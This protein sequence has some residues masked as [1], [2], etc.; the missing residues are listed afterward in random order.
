M[1]MKKI[2][3]VI[4]IC[5][6][7][8]SSC[9]RKLIP[10]IKTEAGKKYD[11]ATFNYVYAEALRQKLMGNN[12]DALKFLE[13]CLKINPN[14]DAV[15]FQMAQIVLGNGDINNG[16]KYLK[17]ALILQPENKWY[18]ILLAGIYYQEKS[19]DSSAIYYEKAIKIDPEKENLKIAL[20]NI[21]KE[22]DKNGMAKVILEELDKKYGTNETT[23][24]A[25]VKILIKEKKFEEAK[26]KV[27]DLLSQD[28][29]AVS[30][31]GLLADIYQKEGN[32]G[33]A[34]DVYRQLLVRNPENPEI[35]LSLCEFLLS[36]REYEELF[37]ALNTLIIN[38]DVAKEDKIYLLGRMMDDSVIVKDFENNV[39]IALMVL[40]A[41]Y[42]DDRIVVLLRPELLTKQNKFKEAS[43]RLEEIIQQDPDN[44]QAWEKLL[45]VY[46]EMR[47]FKRLLPAAKECATR[48]NRSILAK[49]LYS[50]A[51]MEN[52]DYNTALEEL[53]KA[54]ILAGDSK[55]I[56]LQIITMRADI[57]YRLK[58]YEEAFKNFD[59]A[60]KIDENDLTVLNNY[61]YYLAEQNMRLKEAE[62]MAKTVIDK[63]K[64]NTTFLDT[65]AWVLYKRGK[66]REAARIMENIISRGEDDAEWFEHYGFILQ[67]LKKC[68]EA[69]LYWEKAMMLD[70]NKEYLKAEIEKCRK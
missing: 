48:F 65:Y 63:E 69:A 17:K 64:N 4:I 11:E 10:G 39:K 53:R 3:L 26:Q 16:K 21:Y 47:D 25:L 33:K 9:S 2:V 32:K 40:E 23:T 55:D 6:I 18:N 59:E 57:N 49:I 52:K 7:A 30:Y 67:K 35:Q 42:K 44:Y 46:N 41:N 37:M 29:D 60:L 22:S 5:A 68:S 24:V 31:N 19:L 61:A 14:S 20:A 28:P 50:Q 45:L 38:N 62:I 54:D 1:G 56:R 51:A 8:V 15:Y 13:Q 34:F 43:L 66:I 70:K 27:Q 12:G 58:N 36:E